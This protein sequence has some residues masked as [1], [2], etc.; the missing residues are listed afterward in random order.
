MALVEFFTFHCYTIFAIYWKLKQY[1]L[2]GC[3]YSNCILITHST[4]RDKFFRFNWI[5]IGYRFS[6]SKI[7]KSQD[8]KEYLE[9][10]AIDVNNAKSKVEN[11]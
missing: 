1:K 9:L 6:T 4:V 7:W 3:W 2:S 11:I 5:F 10:I 8:M